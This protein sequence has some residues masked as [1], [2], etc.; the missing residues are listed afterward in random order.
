[1]WPNA[2]RIVPAIADVI[3]RSAK[4]APKRPHRR[5]NGRRARPG[6]RAAVPVR[7]RRLSRACPVGV[8]LCLL[9]GDWA[10]QPGQG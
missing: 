3:A 6:K 4:L 2:P 7:H 9:T 8:G 1:M 5:L 10:G